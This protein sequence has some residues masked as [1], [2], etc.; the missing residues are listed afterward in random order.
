MFSTFDRAINTTR[1][2]RYLGIIY[3]I[4]GWLGVV[5][6]LILTAA[7][8]NDIFRF[9]GRINLELIKATLIFGSIPVF[10]F[11]L[12]LGIFRFSKAINNK[13]KWATDVVGYI[14]GFLLLFA[15]PIGTVIGAYTIWVLVQHA[16]AN[17]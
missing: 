15:I 6:S 5:F 11:L 8:C 4:I 2:F 14:I 10:V 16:K 7:A 1:H 9:S 3:N 17:T 12:T 13:Q